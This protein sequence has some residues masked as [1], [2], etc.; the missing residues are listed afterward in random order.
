VFFSHRRA[1]QLFRRRPGHRAGT[2]NHKYADLAKLERRSKPTR[3][4]GGYGSRLKA[5][6]TIHRSCVRLAFAK[7]R[8]ER[9]LP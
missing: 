8:L 4:I 3:G 7:M 2:H 6:T 5:G 9:F 1:Q